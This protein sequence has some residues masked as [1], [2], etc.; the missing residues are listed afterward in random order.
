M[1]LLEIDYRLADL[2]RIT[3]EMVTHEEL[4]EMYIS[5]LKEVAELKAKIHELEDIEIL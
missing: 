3:L 1:T 2:E 4:I 5:K